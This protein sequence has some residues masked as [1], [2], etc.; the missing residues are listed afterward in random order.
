MSAQS[1]LC[2]TPSCVKA[3]AHLL[4]NLH[5][6]Y[7][8]LDPCENF[9]QYVC[10]GFPTRWPTEEDYDTLDE[11]GVPNRNLLKSILD[12]PYPNT[13]ASNPDDEDIFKMVVT[14][15][16]ACIDT[17]SVEASGLGGIPEI[18]DQIVHLFPLEEADYASNDTITEKDYDNMANTIAYLTTIGVPVFGDFGTTVDSQN[19]DKMI[20]WF[21]TPGNIWTDKA[22]PSKGTVFSLATLTKEQIAE[23]LVTV[24][25]TSAARNASTQLAQGLLDFAMAFSTLSAPTLTSPDAIS[26]IHYTTTIA[27]ASKAAPA[28]VLD[29]VIVALAPP[30]YQI[31][32]MQ[33]S[34]SK[35]YT[36][37]SSAINNT[38]RSTI[39]A[40]MIA[41][42]YISYAP[43]VAGSTDP[44]AKR[45]TTCFD[46]IETSLPWIASSFTLTL[47][48]TMTG[49]V[50]KLDW[51]DNKTK[52][53][54]NEK[55]KHITAK[56][57]YPDEKTT[58]DA[59]NA[60]SLAKYYAGVN[61]T[62]SFF[63]NA[64]SLRQWSSNRTWEVLT[65]PFDLYRWNEYQVHSYIPNA[66]YGPDYN[67][68]I[69]PAGISQS[70]VFNLDAPD[71]LSY[72]SMGYIVGHEITH[73][74]DINGRQWNQDRKLTNWW[75]NSSLSG[76]QQR[77]DCFEDQYSRIQMFETSGAPLL[78]AHNRT[79][80]VNG[81]QTLAENLADAG[82]LATAYEAWRKREQ[83]QPSQMLPGLEGFTKDQLFFIA[84][85]QTWRSKAS[86][87]SLL[88]T[89]ATNAHSPA[90]ARIIGGSQSS[91]AFREAWQCEKREP[92]CELW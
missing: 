28:L 40:F 82:G 18:V 81:T 72:G 61:M 36:Q 75:S 69:I 17:D 89:V 63:S 4:E 83:E 68:I 30:D 9:D 54:V 15:Y 65:Q 1:D 50:D 67:H 52:A 42:A 66:R 51:M 23:A 10:G 3:A 34:F 84:F 47:L 70:P 2:L 79:V 43:Y 8:T 33:F 76:F 29:K 90:V 80:F 13:A 39:Q 71:Y 35:D 22:V 56:I 88:N 26:N 85:G 64:L 57:G 91:R 27:E 55:I 25:P 41:I 12:N 24:F 46:H 6:N 78:D 14:D 77:A 74:F 7:K 19:P 21:G 31:D 38:P 48:I 87:E 45:W 32:R 92:V 60:T 11:V 44:N 59:R 5:P 62:N 58:P 53:L 20:P 86:R 73:G 16:N 37:L 49:R